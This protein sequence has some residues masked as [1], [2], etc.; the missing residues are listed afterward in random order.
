MLLNSAHLLVPLCTPFSL[1]A[2]PLKEPPKLIKNKAKQTKI[3][4]YSSFITVSSI[5]LQ[6]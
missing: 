1:V 3:P 2:F 5:N 6:Q 4:P